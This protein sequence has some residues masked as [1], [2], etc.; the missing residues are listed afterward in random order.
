[1]FQLAEEK[2]VTE[3]IRQTLEVDT[4]WRTKLTLVKKYFTIIVPILLQVIDSLLDAF[5]FIK[6]GV[7]DLCDGCN[8]SAIF[9]ASRSPV[10]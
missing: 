3:E 4:S 9:L 2:G 5:Y 1:M 10:W 8:A 6:K 7:P